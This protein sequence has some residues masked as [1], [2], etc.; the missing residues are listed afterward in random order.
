MVR[1]EDRPCAT[2]DPARG[3]ARVNEGDAEARD[4]EAPAFERASE[5]GKEILFIFPHQFFQS[6]YSTR[7]YEREASTKAA[8]RAYV[9]MSVEQDEMKGLLERTIVI[10]H[11]QIAGKGVELVQ[12][13]NAGHTR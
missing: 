3:Q 13:L 9:Q 11:E 4:G 10:G 8:V 7:G 1:L 5:S 12:D 6:T 2:S